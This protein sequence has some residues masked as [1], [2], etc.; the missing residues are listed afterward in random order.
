M[1]KNVIFFIILRVI[2]ERLFYKDLLAW[3]N[4]SRRKPLLLQGARQVG[5]T[6]LVTEFGHREY[7]QVIS[8]NFEQVPELRHLFMDSLSPPSIIEK[9]S[10]Y[11][12]Q[13]IRA[14]NTLLFW[15]EV[16][17]VPQVIT[18]LKYFLEEASE[19]HIIAAGSLLGVSLGRKASF[20]VGKVNF[21][22]LFPLSFR[23]YLQVSGES[24]LA[25]MLDEHPLDQPLNETLHNK[26]LG[27]LKLYLY[28][29]GMPE[30]IKD[31][32][33]HKDI[34]RVREIQVEILEGYGRDF[35]K[36]TEGAGALKTT[37]VWQSIP[38]Q[39]ARENK[40]FVFKEVRK[41]ARLA[42]YEAA[43]EW[44][45]NAG[46]VYPAYRV[47]TPKLP[48]SGYADR[49]KFKLY[50]LDPGLLGA[51]LGVSSD[52]IVHPS[53]LFTE[54]YGAF[55]EN[56]VA[57][58]LSAIGNDPL[59][60]WTS[61]SEAEVDFL[62]Q[63]HNEIFPVEVKSGLS[64]NIKSL[65]SYENRYNPQR[66]FRLSPRNFYQDGSFYNVPLYATYRLGT[67]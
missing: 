31:Y 38:A 54:Y 2:M 10:L 63:K 1:G 51:K 19:Y 61:S 59:F 25:E 62:I 3:K 16:Q 57:N 4:D 53:R 52:I 40:K 56:F 65:R 44:L 43:I 6:W 46:L 49:G 30:V 42:T 20:P 11:L 5:K 50:M 26:L 7:D 41:N 12:G 18:S 22:T 64:R 28:V 13:K 55:M 33:S 24:L 27:L 35:S 36:Y 32:L 48:L 34:A 8:L 67:L 37:E 66:M 47:T 29:G 9:M 23:E 14:E 21:S 45:K 60:Y 58:E 39:L 17:V 15:D